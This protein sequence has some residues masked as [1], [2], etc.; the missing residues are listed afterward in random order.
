MSLQNRTKAG[1]K[2]I[3]QGLAPVP[4]LSPARRSLLRSPRLTR[5]PW[6]GESALQ[7]HDA[8][9]RNGRYH[10]PPPH[11]VTDGDMYGTKRMIF[12][13]EIM[14]GNCHKMIEIQTC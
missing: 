11:V 14:Y 10:G 8:N 2:D 13:D 3:H 12:D 1:Y 9:K 4:P 7:P 6:H 5:R